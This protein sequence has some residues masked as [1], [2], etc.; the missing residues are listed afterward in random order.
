MNGSRRSRRR[1]LSAREE[2]IF[3]A[4]ADG[5]LSRAEVCRAAA[6]RP[7]DL[8]AAIDHTVL[9][10]DAT[11]DDIQKLCDE[12]RQYRF[13]AVCINPVWVPLCAARLDGSSVAVCSVVG[14]PLGADDPETKALAAR[15][16]VQDGATEIDMVIALGHL[17][18]GDDEA[19]FGD[20][21]AVRRETLGLACLKAIIETSLLT[22]AQK[23]RACEIAC[24]AGVDFVKT[25]TGFAAGGATEA[26]VA[27]LRKTVGIDV[28]VKASGGIKDRATAEAM[29]AAGANR[30]GTSSGVAIVTG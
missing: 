23:V 5:G 26:D 24:R 13:A 14:F 30:I 4:Y 3:D 22:D 2:K 7:G 1:D 10:A 8:A 9:K 20:I 21:A 12:A 18:G 25:S 28:G 17:K 6:A 11:A 19:L 27:L 16:A 29:L 15:R